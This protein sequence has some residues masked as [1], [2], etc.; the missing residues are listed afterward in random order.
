MSSHHLENSEI[1]TLFL[2]GFLCALLLIIWS[3][4]KEGECFFWKTYFSSVDSQILSLFARRGSGWGGKKFCLG[5]IFKGFDLCIVAV[6]KSDS[7]SSSAELAVP[8]E[9]CLY[10]GNIITALLSGRRTLGKGDR[11]RT[12]GITPG[13]LIKGLFTK[14]VGREEL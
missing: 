7:I 13:G 14:R 1:S 10:Q 9:V 8:V 2:S 6:Y 11:Q 4:K 12:S 3:R 5:E